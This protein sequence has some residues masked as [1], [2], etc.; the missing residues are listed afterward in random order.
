[1][2]NT[3]ILV[4]RTVNLIVPSKCP[5]QDLHQWLGKTNTTTTIKVIATSRV[6]TKFAEFIGIFLPAFIEDMTV[7]RY[8]PVESPAPKWKNDI[9][10]CVR[11]KENICNGRCTVNVR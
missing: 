8:K 2:P 9:W 10:N 3:V 6:F 1:M 11:Y 4:K 5:M 7:Y